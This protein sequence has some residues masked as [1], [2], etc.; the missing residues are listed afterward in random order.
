MVMNLLKSV[1]R[2]HCI[3]DNKPAS[4][5]KCVQSICSTTRALLTVDEVAHLSGLTHGDGTLGIGFYGGGG[6]GSGYA[7][8]GEEGVVGY[9]GGGDSVARYELMKVTEEVATVV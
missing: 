8:V 7:N 2:R 6:G 9:S 5:E 4:N 1:K 3:Y